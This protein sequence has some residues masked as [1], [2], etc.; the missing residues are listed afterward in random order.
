M[1]DTFFHLSEDRQTRPS[2]IGC[3]ERKGNTE[4]E[5]AMHTAKYTPIENRHYPSECFH[6]NLIG[7]L[8]DRI[9]PPTSGLLLHFPT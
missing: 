9:E 1:V 2:D 6:N 4:I 3:F 8:I 5:L 7:A